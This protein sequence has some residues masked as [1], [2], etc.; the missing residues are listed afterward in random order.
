MRIS[1]EGVGSAVWRL[2]RTRSGS[3]DGLVA[4][5]SRGTSG[6]CW[7]EASAARLLLFRARRV[8]IHSGSGLSFSINTARASLSWSRLR[9]VSARRNR[10]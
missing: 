3:S 10:H 7:R 2:Q 8:G 6:N 5:A 9:A 1:T 4:A